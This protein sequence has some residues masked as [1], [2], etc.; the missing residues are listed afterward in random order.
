MDFTNILNNQII[1]HPKM[2]SDDALK[3]AYQAVFGAAHLACNEEKAKDRIRSEMDIFPV[4]SDEP[5]LEEIGDYCRLNLKSPAVRE[6][7]QD[8]I[9]KLFYYSAS[10]DKNHGCFE[11]LK[12][13]Y[14][15]CI[16]IIKEQVQNKAL[17][18]GK[19]DLSR[20][21]ET[22][23]APSHSSIYKNEYCPSYRVIHK[24]YIRF[25]P[26]L[27]KIKEKL[28]SNGVFT[29]CIEGGAASGKTTA[30]NLISFIF[31][32]PV[33]RAD[34]FFL[35]FDMRGDARLSEIGGNFHYERFAKEVSPNLKSGKAFEYNRFSCHDGTFSKVSVPDFSLITVEGVYSMREEFQSLYD[36]KIFSDISKETQL[37]RLKKRS[38]DLLEKFISL[39]LPMEERYFETLCIKDKCDMIIKE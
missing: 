38:P 32:C 22:L 5:M 8:I 11:E 16:E 17:A 33:I 9:S 12:N 36:L 37:A 15:G 7:G 13:D 6:I 39:W 4:C 26:L 21:I 31:N 2:N 30:A 14:A 1:I 27:R 25:L 10:E 35:P 28:K 18:L 29:L 3:T 24:K 20:A 19:V 23:D 34:D